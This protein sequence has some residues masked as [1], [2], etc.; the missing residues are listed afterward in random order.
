MEE[1]M[2]NGVVQEK[3]VVENPAPVVELVKP[4]KEKRDG[5]PK[6]VA[7]VLF[8]IILLLV[9]FIVWHFLAVSHEEKECAEVV[10]ETEEV[11]DEVGSE[12]SEVETVRSVVAKVRD[13]AQNMLGEGVPLMNVY[14]TEGVGVAY[15]PEGLETGVPM[16]HTFGFTINY[17]RLSV[18]SQA[19]KNLDDMIGN[20]RFYD[21]ISS[22]LLGQGF[23]DTGESY[24]TAS[25]GVAP[26]AFVNEATGVVCGVS[27][28][29]VFNCAYKSW[30]NK[31]NA[32]LS[33][34]LLK[35]YDA[36][37]KEGMTA[38]YVVADTNDIRAGATEPYQVITVAMTGSKAMFYREN[39]EATWHFV[40][41]GQFV[42]CS[43]FDTE[44]AKKAFA[45]TACMSD[46]GVG[47]M[48]V[49][50]L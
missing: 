29:P 47:N 8:V 28:W 35:V 26:V 30:Y 12:L 17:E 42:P 20:N 33:N 41:R 23:V 4:V 16:E 21:T 38:N 27:N 5:F 3:V 49:V 44:G 19:Y 1:K 45:G 40:T 10:D 6:V 36:E 9:G 32:K 15:K 11:V 43:A 31:A 14:D 7:V 37:D 13:V 34:E 2:N 25:T 48:S 39:A 46:D 50:E 18:D 22:V 24:T